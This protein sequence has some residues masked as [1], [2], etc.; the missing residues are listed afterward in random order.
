MF[1]RAS[2]HNLCRSTQSG[3]G[4]L[5]TSKQSVATVVPARQPTISLFVTAGAIATIASLMFAFPE[6]DASCALRQPIILTSITFMGNLLIGRAWRIGSIISSTAAFA[7]SGDKIDA[8]GMARLKVMNVL[9]TLSQLG[10]YVG[11]CGREKIGSNSGIRKAIT[12]ADSI[13]V[14]M[15][16]LIPQ[17]VLQIINL[18]VP[19]VRMGSVETLEG[20]GHY[21]CES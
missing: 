2:F 12:F 3:G 15:V 16:L 6:Y 19:S 8:V 4:S 11:S 17:L 7:A 5:Q 10:S 13:F 18:S 21:T 20:E 1:R 14:V 9:S